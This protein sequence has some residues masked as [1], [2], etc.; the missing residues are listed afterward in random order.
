V[1][2]AEAT[3]ALLG[4]HELRP[5][6]ADAAELLAVVAGQDVV[7]GDD[8]IFRVVAHRE[9]HSDERRVAQSGVAKDERK[10][11]L[12]PFFSLEWEPIASI[13][14]EARSSTRT[15]GEM[16]RRV[17]KV[18][19][20]PRSASK[21]GGFTL[22]ELL[23]VIIILGILAAVVVFAIGGVG[24]KGKS[25]AVA[26]DARTI[27]TAQE[28]YCARNGSYATEDQLVQ[29]GLLAEKSTTHDVVLSSG[30]PC[31]GAGVTTATGFAVA[32]ASDSVCGPSSTPVLGGT[33]VINNGTAA[34]GVTL[35]HWVN[36][37]SDVVTNGA[38]MFNGLLRYELDGS[39]GGDLAQSFTI[40]TAVPAAS[41][42]N[43]A[44][45]T[46]AA[47]C[48][49]VTTVATFV[50]RPNVVFHGA[51]ASVP[52]DGEILEPA[53]VEFS[54]S[55][56]ILA[57][58]SRTRALNP[59]LGVTGQTT[60]T[61]VPPEA[62][63]TVAPTAG[64]GGSVIFNLR[65]NFAPFPFA[66]TVTEAPI[67]SET[68]YG[69][70][71]VAGTQFNVP[72]ATPVCPATISPVGTGP[73]RFLSLGAEGVRTA[74]NPDYF[75]FDGAGNRLPYFDQVFKKVVT[76]TAATSLESG[77]VDVAG[78]SVGDVARLRRDTRINT[79]FPR[80]TNI[81]TIA[82]NMTKRL[83]VSPGGANSNLTVAPAPPG[84]P[85]AVG[86]PPGSGGYAVNSP[87]Y[88]QN[89]PDSNDNAPP[90]KILGDARVREAIFQA[91]DRS[92]I[93]SKV[94]FGTGRVA[95]APIHSSFALPNG[96]AYQGPQPLPP[97]D[98]SAA[99][100]LLNAAG[101]SDTTNPDGFRR[102]LNHPYKLQAN[103][104][105]N[106]PDLVVADGTK[107]AL[108]YFHATGGEAQ[109]ALVKAQLKAVGIDVTTQGGNNN[110]FLV[111]R[112]FHAR[113]FDLAAYSNNNGAEP[114]FG[115]RRLVHTDQVI[116]ANSFAN[117]SGY[118][119]TLMD[120][121]W[122]DAS[123]AP[124]TATYQAKFL[125]LQRMI[126][127][128]NTP[129]GPVL[130]SLELNQRFPVVHVVE[131]VNVRGALAICTGFNHGDTGLYMEAAHCK[132]T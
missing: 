16:R 121:L 55:K 127:G 15:G 124:D 70:C 65:Q 1:K 6:A 20:D 11:G 110:T 44:P 47:I 23:V 36:T 132:R 49:P 123:K 122:A 50:L 126:L 57:A 74:K 109:A 92:E 104:P 90:H 84:G 4:G 19:T 108:E 96:G 21:Q 28:A 119:S 97:F 42:P 48:D 38:D 71:A 56:G 112:V 106:D 58:H 69:P 103:T 41:N 39:L 66:L 59:T 46:P 83:T 52:G 101:W 113:T 102:A 95:D 72:P 13:W 27:E 18:T 125:Q 32:C 78:I 9:C 88:G 5:T 111:A 31:T 116:Q 118:K 37:A 131:T 128:L 22:I 76:G 99:A 77:A 107:L 53:D 94:Q 73:F 43:C 129:G 114:Q 79:S 35:N 81:G 93:W 30:G 7:Q 14:C 67:V 51:N 25:A 33:L 75:R 8:G 3:L 64:N 82:F 120:Q 26:I 87:Y 89:K 24:D 130:T 60:S 100:V 54:F 17:W 105:N 10:C 85:T 12:K 80:S 63:Q 34:P 29:S 117:G 62:I 91:T 61:V 98:K 2:D 40:N 86:L 115:A 68:A 45:T